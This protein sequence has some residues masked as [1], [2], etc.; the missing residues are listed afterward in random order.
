MEKWRCQVSNNFTDDVTG[1]G[2]VYGMKRQTWQLIWQHSCN[3]EQLP[4]RNST[5]SSGKILA[6]LISAPL[7]KVGRTAVVF[8]LR[9][10]SL[11]FWVGCRSGRNAQLPRRMLQQDFCGLSNFSLVGANCCTKN[12]VLWAWQETF[13]CHNEDV[14]CRLSFRRGAQRFLHFLDVKL[15]IYQMLLRR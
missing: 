8:R 9:W 7:L 12:S 4:F 10:N 13:V 6:L 2:E 11:H 3:Y 1:A 14:I 5:F 15:E